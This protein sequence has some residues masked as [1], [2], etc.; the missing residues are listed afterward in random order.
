[1]IPIKVQKQ[2]DELVRDMKEPNSIYVYAAIVLNSDNEWDIE[3][4]YKP[5]RPGSSFE[6][7]RTSEKNTRSEIEKFSPFFT[8]NG[9]NTT[10]SGDMPTTG[11]GELLSINNH[12]HRI[13]RKEIISPIK[14]GLSIG[15]YGKKYK[16]GTLGGLFTVKDNNKTYF[17]TCYH[18]LTDNIFY[19]NPPNP[20]KKYTLVHPSNKDYHDIYQTY[21]GGPIGNCTSDMAAFDGTI[22]A[23]IGEVSTKDISPGIH[24]FLSKIPRTHSV[25]YQN[26]GD[27]VRKQGRSSLLTGGKI[28]SVQSAIRIKNNNY[29][30]NQN[31]LPYQVFTDQIMTGKMATG[32]DS[33][34][35]L[36]IYHGDQGKPAEWKIA[37]LTFAKIDFKK[38]D[39]DI[40]LNQNILSNN[41]RG[42]TF[43]NKIDNIL[44]SP[45]LFGNLNFK[46]FL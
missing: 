3:F 6:A 38:I 29:S 11:E 19:T 13:P 35:S 10:F 34:S 25:E 37:G 31:E 43:H 2:Y 26:I 32:G 45:N 18:N 36:F 9:G 24:N 27:S 12:I 22:D 21:N 4:G 15:N 8:D 39:I 5:P 20:A 7:F 42:R 28:L 14:G 30:G 1:M 41:L 23:I 40:L 16:S 46:T 33:G 17:L 44:Q